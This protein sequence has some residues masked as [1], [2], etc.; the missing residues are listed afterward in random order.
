MGEA[1]VV[2]QAAEQVGA[3]AGLEAFEL[4]V[5]DVFVFETVKFFVDCGAHLGGRVAG[6]GYGV[7]GEEAGVLVAGEAAE[8]LRFGT[9]Y[10]SKQRRIFDNDMYAAL[11]A[12][13]GGAGN[14]L[15]W[16]ERSG[17]DPDVFYSVISFEETQRYLRAVSTNYAIYRRVYGA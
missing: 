2:G 1:F 4:G 6:K 9:Y 5:G 15:L 7:D 8:A 11:A 3:G 14:S 13:N 17:G 12:Y 10:I 16:R